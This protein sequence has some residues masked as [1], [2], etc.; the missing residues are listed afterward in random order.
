MS[1]TQSYKTVTFN[2]PE[3]FA[4]VRALR[5]RIA[6]LSEELISENSKGGSEITPYLLAQ[7]GGARRAL[8]VFE[9]SP[10]VKAI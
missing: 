6:S 3:S 7:L 10:L 2:G 5:Q 8:A 4:V 9:S 1:E